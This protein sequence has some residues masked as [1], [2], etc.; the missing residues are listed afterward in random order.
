MKKFIFFLIITLLYFNN[1]L[2]AQ[3]TTKILKAKYHN[4]F[5]KIGPPE[6]FTYRDLLGKIATSSF[7]VDYDLTV[8]SEAET[9]FNYAVE[10]WSHLIVLSKPIKIKVSFVYE[11]GGMLG[12]TSVNQFRN[13]YSGLPLANRQYP[14]SLAK[15]LDNT[16]IFS[17]YDIIMKF[18]GNL[19]FNYATDGQ[20]VSYQFDFVTVAIHE[21]GHGL[22]L[23]GSTNID[24]NGNASIGF[25]GYP[26]NTSTSYSTIADHFYVSG[27]TRLTNVTNTTTLKNLLLSNNIYFDGISTKLA[28]NNQNVK[29]YAPTSWEGGSSIDHLDEDTFPAGDENSLMTPYLEEAEVNHSPGDIFLAML[30]DYGHTLGRVITFNSPTVGAQIVK[31]QNFNITWYDNISGLGDYINLEL[32]KVTSVEPMFVANLNTEPIF[33]SPG[34]TNNS[35]NWLVLNTLSD[36]IYF[37]NAVGYNQTVNFGKSSNFTISTIP[38]A[39]HFNPPP[40]QYPLAQNVSIYTISP[41]AEI[42]YTTNGSEPT[43]TSTIYTSPIQVPSTLR[44]RAKSFLI[45]SDGTKVASPTSDGDYYIGSNSYVKEFVTGNAYYGNIYRRPW[46]NTYA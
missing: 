20:P 40:G 34:T 17:D 15:N 31:N 46:N 33:S 5:T 22:G 12:E 1:T 45:L 9:A 41:V 43:Q 39:P 2:N 23:Y 16:I 37:L 19:P 44:I 38:E 27:S 21:I 7:D 30:K 32:W 28:N 42:R 29:M 4:A 36:G 10:I 3:P 14:I 26:N 13:N 11:S 25:S 8:P 6:I 24:E 18:N 35:F